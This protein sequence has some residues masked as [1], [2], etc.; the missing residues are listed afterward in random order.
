MT[1]TT[2]KA[3]AAHLRFNVGIRFSVE[4]TKAK[5]KKLSKDYRDPYTKW[6]DEAESNIRSF[7]QDE[8]DDVFRA[9]LRE[10]LLADLP[11]DLFF[12]LKSTKPVIEWSELDDCELVLLE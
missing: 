3:I 4:A 10:D 12:G 7:I 6:E 5:W 2:T 9:E 1:S 11:T 8:L